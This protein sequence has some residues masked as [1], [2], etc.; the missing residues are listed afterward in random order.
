MFIGSIA[1]F[2]LF[3][4]TGFI[5][6]AALSGLPPLI[7]YVWVQNRKGL[8][9]VKYELYKVAFVL[10]IAFASYLTSTFLLKAWPGLHIRA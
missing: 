1:G 3:G 2:Y 10:A 7:Y 5:Y 6:G 4:F 9:I 8:L